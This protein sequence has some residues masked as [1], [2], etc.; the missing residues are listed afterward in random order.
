MW[1][2]NLDFSSLEKDLKGLGNEKDNVLNKEIQ[3]LIKCKRKSTSFEY[4]FVTLLV[5]FV[6]SSFWTDCVNSEIGLILSNPIGSL[7][8]F[9]QEMKLGFNVNP[10]SKMKV[11]GTVDKYRT[12][13]K[14][15]S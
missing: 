7:F 1:I 12:R 5:S 14:T 13:Q 10:Q 2:V 4:D 3:R 15:M 6:D 8:I 11:D 9:L